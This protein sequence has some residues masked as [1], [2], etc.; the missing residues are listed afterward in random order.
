MT[1]DELEEKLGITLTK[2][3]LINRIFEIVERDEV[4]ISRAIIDVCEQD[5][6]EPED[7][8]EMITGPLRDK[9]M[10]EAMDFHTVRDDRGNTLFGL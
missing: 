1:K 7:M 10:N 9:L 5:G 8:A 2:E 3:Q 4:R 6:I